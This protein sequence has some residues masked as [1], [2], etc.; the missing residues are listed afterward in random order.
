MLSVSDLCSRYGAIQALT[1]ASLTVGRGEMVALIGSNGAGK[2]TLLNSIAGVHRPSSGSVSLA[3]RDITGWAPHRVVKAG[4]ALVPEGRRI[5]APLSIEENLRL[6]EYAGRTSSARRQ[7]LK[8]RVHDLFPV[9]AARRTQVAGSLSG[10]EQ[11]MLALARSLMTDP[12]VLLLDEPSMGLAP[13]VVDK[14]YDAIT[15]IH[16]AGQS[17]LLVEQNATLALDVA[18][19]AYVLRRGEIVHAGS[20]RELKASEEL[21]SAYL[22]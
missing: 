18:D 21:V 9:L 19:R 5:V 8:A 12:E 2:S 4:L 22:A 17:I 6:S 15:E 16:R 11:Q 7:E 14:V 1:H 3:G 20:T 13:S 10:G